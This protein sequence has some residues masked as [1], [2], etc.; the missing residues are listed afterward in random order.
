MYIDYDPSFK[1]FYHNFFFDEYKIVLK[2]A[3][4]HTLKDKDN[5][6]HIVT[7]NEDCLDIKYEKFTL[8]KYVYLMHFK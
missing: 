3:L 1:V 4:T 2:I 5:F 8:S 7:H 6:W